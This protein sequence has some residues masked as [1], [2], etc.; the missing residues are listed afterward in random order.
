V[1]GGAP[2]QPNLPALH[3]IERGEATPP[4]S[5]IAMQCDRLFTATSL[6]STAPLLDIRAFDWTC[7]LRRQWLDIANEARG[8][9]ADRPVRGETD[10][11]T[12]LIVAGIPGILSAGFERIESGVHGSPRPYAGRAMLTCQLGLHIPR[13]GDLRMRVGGRMVRWA[14]GETLV[15]DETQAD[16]MWNDGGEAG[17]V[18]TIRLKRPLRQPGRWLADRL[19]G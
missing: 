12:A 16:A 18:L 19:L 7:T 5:W 3:L 6:V 11:R 4:P 2:T 14:E 13:G 15:F 10:P 17:L 9:V 1:E 8:V